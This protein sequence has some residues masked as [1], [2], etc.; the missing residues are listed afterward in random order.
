MPENRITCDLF[1]S[2]TLCTLH[3]YSLGHSGGW[4]DSEGYCHCRN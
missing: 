1:G 2:Q 3:C 4:C